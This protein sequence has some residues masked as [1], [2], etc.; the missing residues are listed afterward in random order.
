MSV[1]DQRSVEVGGGVVT[2]LTARSRW[3]QSHCLVP[4]IFWKGCCYPGQLCPSTC[5]RLREFLHIP[6]TLCPSAHS[7]AK[8]PG[9]QQRPEES[10]CHQGWRD[11]PGVRGR[12]DTTTLGDVGEGR[13]ARGRWGRAPAYGAREAA[14]HP[15]GRGGPCRT[16]HLPG[17][18]RRGAG[19][20]GI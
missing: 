8:G 9:Q 20:E 10:F 19:A 6:S 13:A 4:W 1:G 2:S 5:A 14:A 12:G 15:Q 17:G 7:T 11:S 18:Q 16:L 3:T